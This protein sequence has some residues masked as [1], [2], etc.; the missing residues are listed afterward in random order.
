[1][2]FDLDFVEDVEAALHKHAGM[3]GADDC[4]EILENPDVEAAPHKR[5]GMPDAEEMKFRR[6][7]DI[8]LSW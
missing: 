3:Q 5:A 8:I 4:L 2:D 1:M 7:I 6:E